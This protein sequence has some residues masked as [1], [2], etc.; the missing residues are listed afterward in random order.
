[1]ARIII[2]GTKEEC[3]KTENSL[4]EMFSKCD[5]KARVLTEDETMIVLDV[6]QERC[7]REGF[8]DEEIDFALTCC[9]NVN[10]RCKECPYRKENNCKEKLLADGA[11]WLTRKIQNNTNARK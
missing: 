10:R 2:Q 7:G 3:E 1:M 5:K 9:T 6:Y 8:S 11:L 4:K